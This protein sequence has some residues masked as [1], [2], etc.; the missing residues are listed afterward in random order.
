MNYDKGYF[1]SPEFR[2]LLAKYENSL[3]LGISSYFGIDEFVD[4]LSYY[5]SIDKSEEATAVLEASK[6]LHPTAQE[7]IKMGIR[8]M[9]YSDEASKA[10]ELFK[11][12]KYIDEVEKLTIKAEIMVALRNFK[13]A[14]DI[15]IELLQKSTPGQESVYEGLEILLDCGFAHDALEIC[16]TALKA[17]P[18]QISLYEVKA[19]CLIE[20][21]RIN[22]AVRIYND[23]LDNNS[24][25]TFYWEQLGHI[26][27]MTGK[28]GKSL[29]CFEYESAINEEIEYAYMMQA[30]CYYHLHDYKAA[31][32]LFKRMAKKYSN[33][34]APPFYIGLCH[35]HEGAM[36]ESIEAFN[37]AINNAQEGT[38]S[39]ML[40]RINRALLLDL[41]GEEKIADDAMSMALLMHPDK[42]SQLA[43][44]GTHL[45]ELRDK[46]NLTFD[47]MNIIEVKEWSTE[48]TLYRLGVHLVRHNHPV[49]A[50]RV[51][52][53]CRDLSYDKA[54]ID[55][56]L[57]YI[58]WSAGNEEK[59]QQSIESALD[60]R[61][62]VLFELF[63][64]PYNANISPAAF[65]NKVKHKNSDA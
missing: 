33:A 15:A 16:E 43:L 46:E 20:L 14:H 53:Y 61:S 65:I 58:E 50:K 5:L 30:Y 12:L 1:E 41:T 47:D 19:E 63:G 29:E 26:Y 23:L 42:M 59:A 11:E 28:F 8:L 3:K 22:E 27:Y 4:L 52:N 7:N 38:I 57:A 17:A 32:E 13:E 2:E 39:M 64:I 44:T 49:L 36:S 25:S 9:L 10:I 37:T 54:D 18:Q 24:Y 40:S 45:Y 35:Y 34:V 56:H 55:A 62:N 60:G 51:L 21:Q 6:R 48:E 31:K